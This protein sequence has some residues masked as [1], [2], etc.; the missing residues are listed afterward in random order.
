MTSFSSWGPMF[1]G[2]GETHWPEPA[3]A[4]GG[5]FWGSILPKGPSSGE[6]VLLLL[7]LLLLLLFQ[8]FLLFY[9]IGFTKILKGSKRPCFRIVKTF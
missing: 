5:C 6:D 7:L 2:H 3:A 8:M 4:A 9:T 1:V